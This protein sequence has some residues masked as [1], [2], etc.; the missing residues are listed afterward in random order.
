MWWKESLI[1]DSET[2]AVKLPMGV[3][4][5]PPRVC[6]L[7]SVTAHGM[8]PRITQVGSTRTFRASCG[9]TFGSF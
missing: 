3:L 7:G 9:S 5:S 2:M 6:D 4:E 8:L 1:G